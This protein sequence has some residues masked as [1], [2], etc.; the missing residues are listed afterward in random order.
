M[1]GMARAAPVMPGSVATLRSCSS[2]RSAATSPISSRSANTRAGTRISGWASGAISQV[3]S[4]TWTKPA[5]WWDAPSDIEDHRGLITVGAALK[6]KPVI[7]HPLDDATRTSAVEADGRPQP[8]PSELEP[9]DA[10]R[11][12]I[13]GLGQEL[14]LVEPAGEEERSLLA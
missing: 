8:R 10:V 4:S 7:R 2:E 9:L 12:Q 11:H 5:T 13:L 6:R 14:E 3:T 1:S